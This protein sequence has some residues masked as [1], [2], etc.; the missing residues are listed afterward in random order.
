[1][2]IQVQRRA[3]NRNV[4]QY[5]CWSVHDRG[6]LRCHC[7]FERFTRDC[8]LLFEFFGL[9]YDPSFKQQSFGFQRGFLQAHFLKLFMLRC[10]FDAD[11]SQYLLLFLFDNSGGFGGDKR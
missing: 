10:Q 4:G 1:M 11:L 8:S 5:L 7:L 6:Q 3:H 2:R 9:L